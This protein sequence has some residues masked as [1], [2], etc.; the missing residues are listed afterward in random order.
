[1]DCGYGL[2][3]FHYLVV[4]AAILL[5]EPLGIRSPLEG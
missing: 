5:A 4:G 3:V 1:M 2:Y